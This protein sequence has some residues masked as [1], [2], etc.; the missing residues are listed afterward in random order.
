MRLLLA[1]VF[2][3]LGV[4]YLLRSHRRPVTVKATIDSGAST[5]SF[6][7]IP[8]DLSTVSADSSTS[9]QKPDQD[10]DTGFR[11]SKLLGNMSID[12]QG[13]SLE[14]IEISGGIGDLEMRLTGGILVDGLNRIIISSFIGDSRIYI[15][16]DMEYR[17]HCSN[18]I[19][20]IDVGDQRESGFGNNLESCSANYP[21][22]DKKLYIAVNTFIGDIKVMLV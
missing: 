15:P 14:S 16:R 4:R 1:F 10:S 12:S 3:A 18:F 8:E 11:Y 21:T 13:K 17:V 5:D 7:G 6:E 22:A 20:D 19:G 2:I 9:S